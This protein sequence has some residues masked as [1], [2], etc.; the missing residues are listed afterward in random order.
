MSKRNPLNLMKALEDSFMLGCLFLISLQWKFENVCTKF[1]P[2]IN[3]F[4]TSYVSSFSLQNKPPD[5]E[6][7]EAA[8]K[9][10][11]KQCEMRAI[12]KEII[13]HFLVV[14]VVLIVAYGNHD[15]RAFNMSNEVNN[16][17]VAGD[18][19]MISFNV[20]SWIYIFLF[21]RCESRLLSPQRY[22]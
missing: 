11:L 16:V 22:S 18:P 6:K 12:I 7:L 21:F 17:I 15:K 13:T 8:R 19:N 4:P 2:I 20:V 10:R 3:Y 5:A 9:L 1:N 14:C